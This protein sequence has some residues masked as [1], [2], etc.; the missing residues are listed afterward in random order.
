MYTQKYNL[1][2]RP[3]EFDVGEQ[4]LVLETGHVGK[5]QPKWNGP[6]EVVQQVRQDSY[7][8][9]FP[10]GAEKWVQA[11]H[12]RKYY[13]RVHNTA[14]VFETDEEFGQLET[15][16]QRRAA[17]NGIF[18]VLRGSTH[19]S[20]TQAQE[21]NEVVKK[22]ENTFSEK[23]G[24]STVGKHRITLLPGTTPAKSYPYRVPVALRGEV[25]RQ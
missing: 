7:I 15:I 16:P 4:V 2:A 18:T 25:E 5:M 24:I 1:R 23:P 21:L 9:K 11:N 12:L 8:V 14:V 6:A 17:D 19:L 10:E 20:N 13:V 3:K 22:Y